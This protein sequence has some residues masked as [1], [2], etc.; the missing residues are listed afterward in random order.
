MKFYISIFI[1]YFIALMMMGMTIFDAA[2]IVIGLVVGIF[3][4]IFILFWCITKS[5]LN[6]LPDNIKKIFNA[7]EK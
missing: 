7:E 2:F 1:I 6:Y 4:I 3:S 5:F